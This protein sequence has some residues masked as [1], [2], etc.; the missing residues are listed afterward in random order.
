MFKIIPL[1][2]LILVSVIVY[3]WW[4]DD[5]PAK[6]PARRTSATWLVPQ[7]TAVRPPHNPTLLA[8]QFVVDNLDRAI[9]YYR[10]ALGFTFGEPWGGVHRVT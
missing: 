6:K 5:R 4:R 8:P 2:V 7:S 3:K 9:A 1:C 10:N